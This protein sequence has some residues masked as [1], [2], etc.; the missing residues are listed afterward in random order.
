MRERLRRDPPTHAMTADRDASRV[1]AK[2]LG[3]FG[4]PDEAREWRSNPLRGRRTRQ[5]DG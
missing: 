3:I 1:N 2:T 5:E 4:R